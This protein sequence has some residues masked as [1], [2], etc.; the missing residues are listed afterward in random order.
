MVHGKEVADPV[1]RHDVKECS[2]YMCPSFPNAAQTYMEDGCDGNFDDY[3]LELAA[4][5]DE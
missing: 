4:K 5:T 3:I 1:A 2:Q